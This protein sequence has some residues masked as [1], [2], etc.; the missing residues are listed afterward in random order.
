MVQG[1]TLLKLQK[2]FKNIF[3]KEKILKKEVNADSQMNVT[4]DYK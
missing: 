4:E 2:I 1:F 3:T